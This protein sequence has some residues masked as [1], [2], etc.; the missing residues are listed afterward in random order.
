MATA[1]ENSYELLL[2]EYDSAAYSFFNDWFRKIAE[3][4]GG[5]YSLVSKEPIEQ[6]PDYSIA[7][8][9]NDA[10]G[11]RPMEASAAA[12]FTLDEVVSGDFD[13]LLSA[14]YAMAVE[15]EAQISGGIIAHISE[16]AHRMGNVAAGEL[17]HDKVID[18]IERL[19]FSFDED[20]NPNLNIVVNSAEARTSY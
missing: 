11:G 6:L 4:Q 13:S 18:I 1:E 9:G 10:L 3:A 8:P 14:M 15:M 12:T 20:G 5:I 17:S 2:S 19:E 16:V 7:L